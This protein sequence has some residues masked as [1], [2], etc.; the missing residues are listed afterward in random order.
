MEFWSISDMSEH[1][2][3]LYGFWANI[4]I[5]A[6]TAIAAVAA[7]YSAWF[8]KKAA[9]SFVEGLRLQRRDECISALHECAAMIGRTISLA[10]ADRSL[11][12]APGEV[13]LDKAW[14]S[15]TRARTALAVAKRY[16]PLV[17]DD[18]I[19]QGYQVLY[20]LNSAA[21]FSLNKDRLSDV[22]RDFGTLA[23]RIFKTLR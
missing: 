5:A 3:A 19:Q 13:G 8:T 7:G 22:S 20:R 18:L 11:A 9:Q 14:D 10:E 6:A 16:Y 12:P 17:S 4:I 1:G 2:M 15:W 21:T 23:E